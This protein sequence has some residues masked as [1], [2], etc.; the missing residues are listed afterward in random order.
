MFLALEYQVRDVLKSLERPLL[1]CK[2]ALI[3][4]VI[5]DDDA[6]F[7]WL[8]F[9]ADFE[10]D[11]KET[12]DALLY[13]TVELYITIRGFSKANGWLEKYKQSTKKYMQ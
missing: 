2:V 11:D 4:E 8:I 9:A 13:K 3:E 1:S 10:I 7:H 6:L 12:H 5:A